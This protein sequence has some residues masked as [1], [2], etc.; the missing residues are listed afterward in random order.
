MGNKIL[1]KK[2]VSISSARQMTIP[3]CF[4]KKY[5]FGES[6][7]FID[8]G[9]K[10]VLRPESK[11]SGEFDD[12]ILADLIKEGYEKDELMI[13][14]KKRRERVPFAIN[15]LVDMSKDAANN[16]GEFSTYD[17]VFK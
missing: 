6:A 13:E 15:K 12:E 3:I 1:I 10:L 7:L 17:E 8:E 4:Y 5:G 16:K 2:R 11:C 14:F 9:D